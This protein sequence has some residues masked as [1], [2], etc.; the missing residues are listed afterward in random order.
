M[1]MTSFTR[2]L[3]L[4]LTACSALGLAACPAPNAE[5]DAAATPDAFVTQDA[6]NTVA[7]AAEL[8]DAFVVSDAL[9]PTPDA[10]LLVD[11]PVDAA[12][13][14][15]E[16]DVTI[17]GVLYACVLSPPISRSRLPAGVVIW[18]EGRA[19]YDCIAAST[20][21]VNCRCQGLGADVYTVHCAGLS[22]TGC[23]GLHNLNDVPVD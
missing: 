21:R 5:P 12:G 9:T 17:D 23:C 4:V 11:A 14:P 22:C 15:A 10:A 20:A 19:S 1:R 13:P 3:G 2:S 8:S 6:A 16:R 18:M 7:D